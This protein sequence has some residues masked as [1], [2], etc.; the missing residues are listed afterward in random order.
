LYVPSAY[1]INL[2]IYPPYS[3]YS[4]EHPEHASPDE[5]AH[6]QI[7]EDEEVED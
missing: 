4:Q 7:F 5:V 3:R 2:E 6:R 1:S